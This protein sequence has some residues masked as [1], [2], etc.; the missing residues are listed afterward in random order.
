MAAAD[1]E[2]VWELTSSGSTRTVAMLLSV[3][4][5]SIALVVFV[6]KYAFGS[7]GPNP[8]EKDTREP[9]K[10]MV[11]NRKEKNKVLKQGELKSSLVLHEKHKN[12]EQISYVNMRGK[13]NIYLF[14]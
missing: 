10:P 8:F 6:F 12:T 13:I 2:A 11:H 4:I 9:L 7:S 14:Q 3:V 5:I 1:V